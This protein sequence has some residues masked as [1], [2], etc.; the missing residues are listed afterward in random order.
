MQVRGVSFWMDWLF[1]MVCSSQCYSKSCSISLLNLFRSHSY[2]GFSSLYS[3]L[4]SMSIVH[5]SIIQPCTQVYVLLS[6]FFGFLW[7]QQL[8]VL[9][10]GLLYIKA[11]RKATVMHLMRWQ[12]LLP[13]IFPCSYPFFVYRKSTFIAGIFQK[14]T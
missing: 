5:L 14:V 1:Q 3:P 13:Q 4:R 9:F 7:G 11:A 6:S 8:K 12:Q 10:R 2:G